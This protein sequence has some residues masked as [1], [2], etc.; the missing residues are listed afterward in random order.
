MNKKKSQLLISDSNNSDSDNCIV[1]DTSSVCDSPR[2]VRSPS[3]Q[4]LKP[5][6]PPVEKHIF[7][8]FVNEP[9]FLTH[10]TQY[11]EA[12]KELLHTWNTNKYTG[13]ISFKT[14]T[15]FDLTKFNLNQPLNMEF[16]WNPPANSKL[17]DCQKVLSKKCWNNLFLVLF[18]WV[19]FC[20]W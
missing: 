20:C 15:E 17:C 12:D 4:L 9:Y 2:A 5:K 16:Q 6:A 19:I 8:N 10:C 1:L 18:W 11:S 14:S 7:Q 13:G 3:I